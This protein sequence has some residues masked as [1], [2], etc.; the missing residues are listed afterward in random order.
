MDT[1]SIEVPDAVSASLED[2]RREGE[3]MADAL[4]RL[5]GG[6]HPRA[7]TGSLSEGSGDA[8][9]AAFEARG[10]LTEVTAAGVLAPE[11][12]GSIPEGIGE[13]T[14]TTLSRPDDDAP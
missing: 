4:T 1:K 6:P 11:G 5:V 13:Q 14:D 10:T 7:L 12:E 9:E 8:M 3:T 2:S